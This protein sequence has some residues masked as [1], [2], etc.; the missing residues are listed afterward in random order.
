MLLLDTLEK[1]SPVTKTSL[2]ESLVGYIKQQILNGML[3]P[4][5]RIVETKIAEELG[6]SQTPVREALRQ[7]SGEGIVT[8]VPNKGP[9]V[10]ALQMDDVFEIYSI[11]AGLEGLSMR[12][13]TQRA[14]DAEVERLVAFHGAMEAKA[15]DE[16]VPVSSLLADSVSVHQY[17]VDLSRHSRLVSMYR[18]ISFQIALV[19][20]ILGRESTKQK[21]VDQHREVVEALASRDPD[22]AEK[23]MRK[24]IHRSYCEFLDVQKDLTSEHRQYIWF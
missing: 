11:R 15:A 24:H 13:A 21:E 5:D 16:A 9:I 22:F 19:N 4:G 12:F 18:S 2:S 17:I 1:A 3:N 23:V 7:L 8:L 14:T 6:I 20:R 10:R